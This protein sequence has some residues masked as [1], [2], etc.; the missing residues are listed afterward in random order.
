MPTRKF[1]ELFGRRLCIIAALVLLFC[2]LTYMKLVRDA[3]GQTAAN[4]ILKSVAS[5]H[6]SSITQ[7]DFEFRSGGVEF[8]ILLPCLGL[9]SGLNIAERL[10]EVL[11]MG[12]LT[13]P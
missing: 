1:H 3:F 6:R 5:I 8:A 9:S 12:T 4:Q 7:E 10:R 13:P 2:F 11:Q